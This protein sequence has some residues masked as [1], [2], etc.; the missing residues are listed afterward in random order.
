LTISGAANSM[1]RTASAA[2]ADEQF[3]AVNEY[4]FG[5][6]CQAHEQY[7]RKDFADVF[8]KFINN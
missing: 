8:T 1:S 7:V 6:L 2:S 3:K 4:A 5:W